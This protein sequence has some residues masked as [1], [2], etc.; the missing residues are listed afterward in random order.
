M[1]ILKRASGKRQNFW[2]QIFFQTQSFQSNVS[3]VLG[4]FTD[5][6]SLYCQTQTAFTTQDSIQ[7]GIAHTQLV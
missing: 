1:V 4:T 5:L 3:N 2:D 6:S 7:L